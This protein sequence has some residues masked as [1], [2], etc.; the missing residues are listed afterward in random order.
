M[1]RACNMHRRRDKLVQNF[2]WKILKKGDHLK[3][4]V[5]TVKLTE[6]SVIKSW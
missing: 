6:I 3:V 4:Y 5:K 2:G 1:G